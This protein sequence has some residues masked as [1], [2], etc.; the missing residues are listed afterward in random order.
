MADTTGL[1]TEYIRRIS[2][3]R[4]NESNP[5]APNGGPISEILRN[6]NQYGPELP[7]MALQ[8]FSPGTPNDKT[9]KSG[10]GPLYY[11]SK[12]YKENTQPTLQT[13]KLLSNE[14][15]NINNKVNQM[16]RIR[17]EKAY[18][19]VSGKDDTDMDTTNDSIAIN[20]LRRNAMIRRDTASR[21]N[22]WVSYGIAG[23]FSFWI[24]TYV[25]LI[26]TSSTGSILEN[27]IQYLDL[28]ILP[29]IILLFMIYGYI[30]IPGYGIQLP[31]P[32]PSANQLS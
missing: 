14:I 31:P 22:N 26:L 24:F 29:G 16:I 12:V 20:D 28:M 3:S 13:L 10:K 18:E 32:G 11:G 2:T 19:I 25:Y 23:I 17:G 8:Q 4:I 6:S 21:V 30:F 7:V 27:T 1:I 5:V 15:S 9:I